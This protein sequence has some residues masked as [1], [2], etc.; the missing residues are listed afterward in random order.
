METE[1]DLMINNLSKSNLRMKMAIG[2]L[3]VGC[4]ISVVYSLVQQ[5]IAQENQRVAYEYTLKLNE[6]E[7]EAMHQRDLAQD[8]ADQA[9]HQQKI[10]E[11]TLRKALKK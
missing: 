7:K 4:F 2:V 3:I 11:E 6:C 1:K 8:A 5:G 10:A 9:A